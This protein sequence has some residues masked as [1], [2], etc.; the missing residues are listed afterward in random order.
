MLV[1]FSKKSLSIGT[2]IAPCSTAWPTESTA[3]GHPWVSAKSLEVIGANC[4]LQSRFQLELAIKRIGPLE[5]V[6]QPGSVIAI[7]NASHQD[8]R[9]LPCLCLRTLVSVRWT[10]VPRKSDTSVTKSGRPANSG[11]DRF[12]A[13]G[14][15]TV[16][17]TVAE[18][19][20]RKLTFRMVCNWGFLCSLT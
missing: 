1:A 17:D 5:L 12:T 16:E 10:E 15:D 2:C 19:N 4:L 14:G 3:T 11:L 8:L 7:F 13:S 18:W 20:E 6:D 9:I